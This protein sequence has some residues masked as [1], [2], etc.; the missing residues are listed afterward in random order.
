MCPYRCL[1]PSLTSSALRS[2]PP[3]SPPPLALSLIAIITFS[4]FI[5]RNPLIRGDYTWLFTTNEK[6]VSLVCAARS[7]M[8]HMWKGNP[9]TERQRDEN[10][11]PTIWV[12][13]WPAFIFVHHGWPMMATNAFNEIKTNNQWKITHFLMRHGL[14]P[15]ISLVGRSS[16]M[17]TVQVNKVK[18][19]YKNE[20]LTA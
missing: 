1:V 16:L 8:T 3:N 13:D 17:P 2:L 19:K 4:I 18:L 6:C 14:L 11:I 10:E 5:W 9:S 15:P 7:L 12:C 20:A